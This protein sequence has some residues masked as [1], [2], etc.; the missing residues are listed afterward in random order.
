MSALDV[1]RIEDRADAILARIPAWMW[2]G[3]TLPVPVETIADSHYGILIRDVDDL[4]AAPGCPPLAAG[5]SLSGLLLAGRGE[6]WVNAAEAREWPGR[7]RFTICHE[8]GHWELHRSG[9]Q[10]L[11]CRAAAVEPEL[12]AADTRPPLPVTEAEANAFAAALLIPRHQ[13]REA[14]AE[15]R[16][17][18]RLCAK[19]GTS[20]R[21]MQKRMADV[22]GRPAGS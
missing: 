18:T 12:A 20:G 13:L 8:L 10:A 17:F 21:A 15:E 5:H 16:D 14:Y 7:R 11:F 22:I 3:E 1:E 6:I 19:F 4:T 9:Q 2:D